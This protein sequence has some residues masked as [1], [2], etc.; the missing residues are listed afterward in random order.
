MFHVFKYVLNNSLNILSTYFV[1]MFL[2]FMLWKF[3]HIAVGNENTGVGNAKFF[4]L[5]SKSELLYTPVII[6]LST[7][8][9]V[10]STVGKQF[11]CIIFVLI[12]I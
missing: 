11:V 10:L 3:V 7:F 4:Q 2:S 9:T 1:Y 8:F 6:F 12:L 5:C